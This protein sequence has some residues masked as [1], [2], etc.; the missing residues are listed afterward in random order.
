ME[1][2]AISFPE[3]PVRAYF[4]CRAL[5]GRQHLEGIGLVQNAIFGCK[6]DGVMPGQ[7]SRIECKRQDHLSVVNGLR[8]DD[9]LSM[10][11]SHIDRK[12]AIKPRRNLDGKAKD[13]TCVMLGPGKCADGP[14]R[15]QLCSAVDRWERPLR[16]WRGKSCLLR[17]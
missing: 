7:S 6:R 8:D 14:D 2:T 16:E 11:E 13:V 3:Q 10:V 9:R 1:D 15:Y 17:R 4:I 12:R 5:L